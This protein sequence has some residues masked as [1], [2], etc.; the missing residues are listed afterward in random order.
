[1]K[2]VQKEFL[3]TPHGHHTWTYYTCSKKT[4]I[5]LRMYGDINNQLGSTLSRTQLDFL[6]FQGN[7]ECMSDFFK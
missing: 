4:K 7:I 3:D 2:G 1:M 6:I 5:E